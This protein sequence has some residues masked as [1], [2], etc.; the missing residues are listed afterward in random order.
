M[1]SPREDGS[2]KHLL[3]FSVTVGLLLLVIAHP[4][5]GQ[6]PDLS[7]AAGP[8]RLEPD[9]DPVDDAVRLDDG[10]QLWFV[11]M[12]GPPVVERGNRASIRAEQDAFRVSASQRGVAF[13]ER[14]TFQDLWNGLSIA[15]RPGDLDELRE[16]ST[17]AALYPVVAIEPPDTEPATEP[18]LLT[19]L[20]MT[21]A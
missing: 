18:D 3:R 20:A 17:V 13:T 9:P 1:G 11:E 2:M 21:G 4:A 16:L 12:A 7:A 10:R 5:T 15:V 14:R 19:A 6:S 8:S